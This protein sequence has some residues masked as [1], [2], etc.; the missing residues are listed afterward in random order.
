[1]NLKQR[2]SSAKT[3][4]FADPIHWAGQY[5]PNRRPVILK[6]DYTF[7]A[8]YLKNWGN[9]KSKHH[10]EIM[11]IDP[12]ERIKMRLFDGADSQVVP[13]AIINN[14]KKLHTFFCGENFLAGP[15]VDYSTGKYLDFDGDDSMCLDIFG[16][17][18]KS[19][20]FKYFSNNHVYING[21]DCLTRNLS[22][23]CES[24][25][26]YESL[27]IFENKT[28]YLMLADYDENSY[29]ADSAR[30]FYD[31]KIDEEHGV[32]FVADIEDNEEIEETVMDWHERYISDQCESEWKY[33]EDFPFSQIQYKN[34]ITIKSA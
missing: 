21:V 19:A 25:G 10:S 4:Y 22:F 16:K 9:K 8:P 7:F 23:H 34:P 5:Y 27:S 33:A 18:I 29:N 13:D 1:M 2:L 24:E 28:K 30:Y 12:L 17:E 32:I 20:H 31:G 15:Q 3:L 14:K 11:A 6:S 26:I